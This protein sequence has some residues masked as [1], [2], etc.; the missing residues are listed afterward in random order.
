MRTLAVALSKGGV[1]KTTTAINLA[2]GLALAGKRVLLID[3]DTQG[4]VAPS[5]GCAAPRGLAEVLA[6]E[7]A[8]GL[9]LVQARPRLWVLAGG[10]ALAGSARVMARQDVG[11]EQVLR[12][13]LASVAGQYDYVVLDT[14]PGWDSMTV[15]AL[16]YVTEV[17]TPVALDVLALRGLVDFQHRL[18]TLQ[19]YHPVALRYVL[20]TF[21]DLRVRKSAEVL[22][23]LRTH[24]APCL[25]APIRY[26]ARLAE[27]PAYGRT[28]YEAAPA[29]PGAADYREL[30]ARVLQDG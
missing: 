16:F 4:Q 2:A 18:E 28:I 6:G 21:L 8:V 26:N 17:L 15:N 24:Y 10:A 5:L 22:D 3:T 13:A 1:G 9:A 29:A 23:Q 27:A 14:A 12:E 30:T 19:K 7:C 20:P 11:G 25:C